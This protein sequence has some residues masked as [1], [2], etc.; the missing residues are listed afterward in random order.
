MLVFAQFSNVYSIKCWSC[1]YA[2]DENGN[3]IAIPSQ[4]QDQNVPFCGV[5]IEETKDENMTKE[6]PKVC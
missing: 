6:Y 4:F 2:E 3:R 1:G 5:F